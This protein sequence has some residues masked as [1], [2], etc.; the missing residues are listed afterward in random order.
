MRVAISFEELVADVY[1]PFL[2]AFRV[3]AHNLC[4]EGKDLEA[5]VQA[6]DFEA[7][8]DALAA[9]HNGSASEMSA[10]AENLFL[11]FLSACKPRPLA[12]ES[13]TAMLAADATTQVLLLSSKPHLAT[14]I[15]SRWLQIIQQTCPSETTNALLKASHQSVHY[16]VFVSTRV[17]ICM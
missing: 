17:Y 11:Q 14:H 4:G 3:A 8:G 5:T 16:S 10:L 7:H 1:S 12:L 2:C 9:K 13:I 15:W 6:L